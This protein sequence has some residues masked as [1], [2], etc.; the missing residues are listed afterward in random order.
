MLDFI[1]DS[2]FHFPLGLFI[3]TMSSINYKLKQYNN[4]QQKLKDINSDIIL[5]L[6]LHA[7]KN[8]KI[9]THL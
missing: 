5:N 6:G 8:F 1:L 2:A 3:I 9:C 4:I 7:L